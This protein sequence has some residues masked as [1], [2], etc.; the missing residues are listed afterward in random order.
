MRF[1][2]LVLAMIWVGCTSIEID[3]ADVFEPKPTITPDLFEHQAVSLEEVD[4][5]AAGDSLHLNAWWLTREDAEATVLFFGGQ[6][7]Y[8]VQS[9]GYVEAFTELPVNVLMVDYRG[10][11]KSEGAPS[12]Q[13]L[14]DDSQVALDYLQQTQEV[15]PASVIVHGHSLGTFVGLHLATSAPVGGVMLENPA[16]NADAWARQLVPWFLRLFVSLQ[17]DDALRGEDNIE[18]IRALDR[19]VLIAA[20][21]ADEVTP[22]AMAET[23]YD[24]TSA[25]DKELVRIEEG[26]HNGLHAFAEYRDAYER[27]IRTVTTDHENE[28]GR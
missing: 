25:A 28:T 4:L 26:G 20:G 12:V 6:G 24:E 9:S 11:G 13:A 15:D 7:F 5:P 10:Y 8:L 22:P 19:P 27:L 14:K 18:R 23:L 2:V 21:G 1:G 17:F 16:T 3:E